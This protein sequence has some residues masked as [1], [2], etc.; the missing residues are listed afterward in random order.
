MPRLKHAEFCSVHSLWLP[1]QVN[2]DFTR[3]L[4]IMAATASVEQVHMA[5]VA[6]LS[7]DNSTRQQAQAFLEQSGQ[8]AGYASTLLQIVSTEAVEEGMLTTLAASACASMC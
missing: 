3:S 4:A 5:V 8:Q 7:A 2:S 6:A 1:Q